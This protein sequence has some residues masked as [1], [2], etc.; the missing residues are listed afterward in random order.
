MPTII[1]NGTMLVIGFFFS[2]L[3]KGRNYKTITDITIKNHSENIFKG[4][5]VIRNWAVNGNHLNT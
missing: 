2:D 4:D 1:E 5:L 3:K